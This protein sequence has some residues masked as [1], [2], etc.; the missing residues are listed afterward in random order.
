MG[1]F[2][3]I[4]RGTPGEPMRKWADEVPN[5]GLIR[6]LD[7]FNNERIVIVK[8]AALADVLVHNNYDWEKPGPLRKGISR[9]LGMG[10]FL[11]EGDVHKVY[12]SSQA[13][14]RT[15]LTPSP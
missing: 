12:A 4:H 11:A 7:F 1:Q 5:N 14:A 13:I 3:G 10:L 8:P 2:P 6:Y 15:I 9:I